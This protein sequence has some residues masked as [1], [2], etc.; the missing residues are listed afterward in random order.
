MLVLPRE[1]SSA[2]RRRETA[3]LGSGLV[4]NGVDV[5]R[6][7]VRCNPAKVRSAGR[8]AIY[9]LSTVR[10]VE[11]SGRSGARRGDHPAG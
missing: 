10:A 4:A 6:G 1:A 3:A 7:G 9:R 8:E 11:V 2:R 5:G